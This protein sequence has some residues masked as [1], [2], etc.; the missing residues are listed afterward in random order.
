[1]TPTQAYDE[2]MTGQPTAPQRVQF[3]RSADGARIAFAVHGQGPPLL[4]STCWLSHLQFDW[5]SPV[6]RHFLLGLGE[7]CTVIRFDERGHG[8]SDWDVTDHSLAARVGDLEA[9]VEAAGFEQFALMAMAQ[10]GPVAISYAARHPDRVTRLLFYGSYSSAAQGLSA[11]ELDVEDT[12]GQMIK[13]GWARPDSTFRRVFTSLMIPGA[14]EEQMRWLD[15]LQRVAASAST[16]YLSRQQRFAADA[17]HLLAE[18]DQPTLVLHSVDDRMNGF[19]YGRHLA[20]SIA[21]ARLVPLESNNHILL[22]HEP[23][24]PV[25]LDEVRRFM[26]ADGSATAEPIGELLTGRE[27]EVL[28]LAAAGLD[29]DAIGHRLHLSTRTIERHLQNVYAKLGLSGRSARIAATRRL[30]VSA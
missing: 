8:L 1:M 16:A 3:C 29:N 5:E 26:A 20:S 25:F 14:S 7:F 10:G 17:D 30:L 9:V 24:W 4:I 15:D 19:A 18:L 27:L 23:A 12:F 2:P 21:D 6:W 22:E 13:V 28:R 11:D